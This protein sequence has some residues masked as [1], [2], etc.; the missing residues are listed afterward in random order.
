M[1]LFF[2]DIIVSIR[3]QRENMVIQIFLKILESGN[4]RYYYLFIVLIN[5]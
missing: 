2:I 1:I 3:N 4:L 5:S